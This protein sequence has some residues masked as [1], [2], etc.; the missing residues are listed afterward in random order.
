M[1][2]NPHR[3][4]IVIVCLLF[5][6][7]KS[8][9]QEATKKPQTII[10]ESNIVLAYLSVNQRTVIKNWGQMTYTITNGYS[11]LSFRGT[12]T[13]KLSDKSRHRIAQALHQQLDQIPAIISQQEVVA[14]FQKGT[15]CPLI[16]L[17]FEPMKMTLNDWRIHLFRFRL[18][19]KE[20][21]QYISKVFCH[22]ARKASGRSIGCGGLRRFNELLHGEEEP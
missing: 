8:F 6:S 10:T 12:L 18:E 17:E 11:D 22:L 2:P 14:N 5:F 13:Y 3:T 15:E 19:I 9:A 7:G 4:I 20:T 1:N 21:P 16:H